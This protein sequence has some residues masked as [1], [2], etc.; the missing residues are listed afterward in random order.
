MRKAVLLISL[1]AAS[2]APAMAQRTIKELTAPASKE[3]DSKP[4]S[5]DVPNVYAIAGD[6]KRV[7]VLRL[8]Y[9]TDLLAG[10][11][12]AVKAQNI[13]NAVILAGIGS[14]RNYHIH[15]VGNRT[16]P[17]KNI[18]VKDP[19]GPADLASMN[20]YVINGRVH[21]HVM[22]TYADKAFGGHLEPG[23]GVFT[24]A[25]VTLGILGDDVNLKRVDDMTYR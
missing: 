2:A 13:K 1:L 3:Q 24:F 18:Y 16:F 4:N 17:N 11:E 9:Q 19:T 23:T 20:G 15:T 25:I 21:A 5:P 8:K 14:V 6:F 10:I 7:V 12:E 22:L